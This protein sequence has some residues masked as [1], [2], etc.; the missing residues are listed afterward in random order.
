MFSWLGNAL[1]SGEEENHGLRDLEEAQLL[2][3]VLDPESCPSDKAEALRDR[4][5]ETQATVLLQLDDPKQRVLVLR[6]LGTD[7]EHP[8]MRHPEVEHSFALQY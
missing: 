3:F 4:S 1:Y 5:P 2:E 8:L 6:E 7:D